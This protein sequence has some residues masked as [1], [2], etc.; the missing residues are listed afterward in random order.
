M[1][2]L[3][4]GEAIT[5]AHRS[6]YYQRAL[7]GGFSVYQIVTRVFV[8]NILLVGLALAIVVSPSRTTQIFAP[9]AGVLLVFTL[10]RIFSRPPPA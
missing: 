1:R 6:H 3:A 9:A 5:S 4:K 2:R 7:D 8:L 10:L